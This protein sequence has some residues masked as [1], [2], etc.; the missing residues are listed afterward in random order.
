V[1]ETTANHKVSGA[2]LLVCT[3]SDSLSQEKPPSVDKLQRIL[4]RGEK[5]ICP[6]PSSGPC[7]SHCWA[8]LKPLPNEK[9]KREGKSF[10]IWKQSKEKAKTAFKEELRIRK[11]TL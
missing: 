7:P 5:I 4:Q 10:R 6:A 1:P 8:D 2:S 3:S 11:M 9:E